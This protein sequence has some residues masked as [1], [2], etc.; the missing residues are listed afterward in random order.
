[1]KKFLVSLLLVMSISAVF[2]QPFVWPNAWSAAEPGAATYG[3]T[4]RLATLSGSRT[5]NPFVSGESDEI[6]DRSFYNMTL[7]IR[8]PA[9][10]EFIPY[11]AESF[12]VSDDGLVIDM[13]IREGMMWSDG[14]PITSK[15]F[16]LYYEATVDEEVESPRY[17][18]FLIGEELIQLEAPTDMSLRWTFPTQDREALASIAS[19]PAP[20]HILGEIYREGGAEALKAAWGTETPLDET[21]WAA[22]FYPTGYSPDERYVFEK[23]PSYGEWNVDAQGNALPY[24]DGIVTTIADNDAQLNLY[25]A[26]ELDTISAPNADELSVIFN[27]IDN[28]DIDATVLDQIAQQ[29]STSLYVFNWN[30]ADNPFKEVLFRNAEFRKAMSHL[31]PREALVDLVQAGEA[32][33]AYHLISP[34]YEDWFNND[35]TAYPYDPEEATRL[36]AGLG[37]TE[38]ND[39]GWLVDSD[40]NVL[41]FTLATIAS[42]TDA[43]QTIQI[44]ADAMREAGVKA[45]TEPLEFSLLVDQLLSE[46]DSRPFD[47]IYIFFGGPN[48]DWPFSDAV[49][50]CDAEFHMWNGSGE[51]LTAQESLISKLATE[52]RSTL[53]DAE[54]QQIGYQIMEEFAQLQPIIYTT[55]STF[56]FTW[57]NRLGGNYPVDIM[58]ALTG[59]R[60]ATLTF[61]QE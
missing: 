57:L 56:N 23:N 7:V 49:L 29:T 5:F 20:D 43:V 55:T 27:A 40:G 13:V 15:D 6:L 18:S 24:A 8:D 37:F 9:T 38:R 42:N 31:T 54:A 26:G 25:I 59:T 50:K 11:M 10:R 28:G 32:V 47:A 33:P 52:G 21:A 30:Q 36:L 19:P 16:L 46:G 1:M 12:S 44:I 39:D 35:A 14:T 45:E 2:A 34:A 58:S 17:D 4:L 3:G 48:E 60:T 51:C 41:E 53:D 61:I 22:A